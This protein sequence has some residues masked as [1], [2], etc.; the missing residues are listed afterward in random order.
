MGRKRVGGLAGERVVLGYLR[1]FGDI[2][3]RILKKTNSLI[4]R[5]A[6]HAIRRALE[7]DTFDIARQIQR[8]A[9]EQ[10]ARF[11][12]EH[13]ADAPAFP[14]RFSLL[15]AAIRQAP[16]DGL[17]CEFGVAGGESLNFIAMRVNR[18]VYGFDSFDGLPEDWPGVLKRGAF[19]QERLP[20]VGENVRLI[21][22]MFQE[23]LPVFVAE[24]PE[25]CAML[26]IDSDL[27]ASADTVLRCLASKI[28]SGTVIVF[29]EF[30]NSPFWQQGES[31]AF[32][33][34]VSRSQRAFDYLG[35]A[36]QQVAVTIT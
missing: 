8:N 10:T 7:H 35:Y 36:C 16:S 30:F 1:M 19:Q 5:A 14:D 18:Q 13:M 34:F 25:P 28:V 15:E 12:E 9:L 6:R 33:E 31:R 23:T 2:R 3:Q 32:Q 11:I 24:H 17:V 27:Y 4:E 22:G 21:R 20:Q 26:H 29:D